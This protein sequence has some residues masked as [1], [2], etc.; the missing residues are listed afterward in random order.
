[1]I[2]HFMNNGVSVFLSFAAKKGWA[3]G[4]IFGWI[5]NFSSKNVVLG[6]I[7]FVLLLALFVVIGMELTK[8]IIKESFKYSFEKRQKQLANM[9]IR[10]SYFKQIENIK[11]GQTEISPMFKAE[12]QVV[13]LDLS[14]FVNFVSKNFEKN[15]QNIVCDETNECSEKSLKQLELKT[16]ILLWG[17]IVLGAIVTFMTFIWGIMR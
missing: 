3:I 1:M 6:G 8:F 10:E 14:Q 13:Y 7:F 9:A 4:N 11:N 15:T 12:R 2:V 16:K 17:S 5:S